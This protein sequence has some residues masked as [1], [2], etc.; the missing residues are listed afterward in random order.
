MSS[1]TASAFGRKKKAPPTKKREKKP[2]K[3]RNREILRQVKGYVKQL[4]KEGNLGREYSSEEEGSGMCLRQCRGLEQGTVKT[5]VEK[6][7]A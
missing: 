1:D 5:G 4:A 3:R 2:K 6:T 7:A